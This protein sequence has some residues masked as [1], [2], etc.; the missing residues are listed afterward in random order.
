MKQCKRSRLSYTLETAGR[1]Q[2]N[3]LTRIRIKSLAQTIKERVKKQGWNAYLVTFMFHPIPGG[4]K[5]KIQIMSEALY[6]FYSKFLTRVVR[7]PHSAFQLSNRP[8]FYALPDY[9]VFKHNKQSRSDVFINDG[10]HVH[11]I[12]AVPLKSRLK[13]DAKGH[14]QEHRDI[15][16]KHPLRRI[17]VKEIEHSFGRVCDY[18]FKAIKKGRFSWDDLIVLPKSRSELRPTSELFKEMVK[19]IDLGLYSRPMADLA[20]SAEAMDPEKALSLARA[21]RRTFEAHHRRS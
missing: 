14:I 3:E 15:Y 1:L 16:T 10:L 17:H 5:T 9:P 13:S 11:A 12:L 6:G 2:Y 20:P 7:N 19:W 8:L 21:L 4:S 18:A